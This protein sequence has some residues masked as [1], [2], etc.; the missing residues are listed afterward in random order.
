MSLE[1]FESKLQELTKAQEN[2]I[3]E[4]EEYN[5]KI[6]ETRTDIDKL[7]IAELKESG[8]LKKLKWSC[9]YEKGI[10]AHLKGKA[11]S[12]I[13][14]FLKSGYHRAYY[15]DELTLTI[16]DDDIALTFY[17]TEDM[18]KFIKDLDLKVDY[19]YLTRERDHYEERYNHMKNI[20]EKLGV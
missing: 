10:A 3:K 16:S 20:T 9:K 12:D 13:C 4:L 19:V 2:I 11:G 5:R 8:L 14:D 6:E 18:V 17:H 15:S 7:K 1:E